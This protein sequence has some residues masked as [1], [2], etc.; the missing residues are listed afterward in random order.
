MGQDF[1]IIQYNSLFNIQFTHHT[2]GIAFAEDLVIMTTAESTPEAENV[3]NVELS[4]IPD[5][6]RE[7]KLQFN[8]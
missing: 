6:A 4:N 8:E 7:N 5:W 3:M 2:K 1:W